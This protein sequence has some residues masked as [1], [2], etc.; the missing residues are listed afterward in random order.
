MKGIVPAVNV[1]VAAEKLTQ[2]RP[3]VPQPDPFYGDRK[4][5]VEQW[6]FLASTYLAAAGITDGPGCIILM[7][8]YLRGPALAWWRRTASLPPAQQPTTWADFCS[9]LTATFQPINPAET[10]RDE[11][12]TLRQ[13]TSVRAYATLMRNAALDVPDITDGELKD[14]FIRGLKTQTMRDVRMRTP[15]TFEQ[16]VQL[17]ERYD[18]MLYDYQQPQHAIPFGHESS[19]VPMELGTIAEQRSIHGSRTDQRIGYRTDSSGNHRTSGNNR[20]QQLSP[21]MREQ[22]RRDGKCF[23]CHQPGHMARDCQQRQQDMNH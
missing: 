5:N 19:P 8:A 14:R 15:A 7:S 3:K 20:R 13:T 12:A 18:T 21:E 2:K 23:Y 22:L 16:A 6:I 10:A 4:E 17:A 9:A 11:L 1:A